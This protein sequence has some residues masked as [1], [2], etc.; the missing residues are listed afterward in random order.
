MH[1]TFILVVLTEQCHVGCQHCGYIGSKRD[2][3]VE[4]PELEN[5]LDQFRQYGIPEVIFTGG[6]AFERYEL[7]CRGVERARTNG[8]RSGVFTSAFWATSQEKARQ[9]LRELSGLAR[10]HISTDVYHQ[11]RIPPAYVRHA[12]DAALELGIAN[13]RLAITYATGQDKNNISSQFSDY[14][15]RITIYADRVIPNP[16]FSPRV[17]AGQDRLVELSP[18]SYSRNC[19]IGTPLVD[20]SGE[21]FA[22]HIG[23]AAAHRDLTKLPF[24][25]GNLRSSSFAT[26]MKQ[27]QERPD[28]Q[29]LRT[30]GPRGVAEMACQTPSLLESLPRREFT[31][32][33]DMCM[34]ILKSEKGADSLRAYAADKR[35]T[36]NTVLAFRMA[37]Q[38]LS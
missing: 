28:Y 16:K 27:A 38:P 18:K 32:A 35:D 29:F 26:I 24:Y 9:T 13:I 11:K 22:C 21:I 17:L 19:W 36:I 8:L 5:W 33:C 12:I 2:G 1:F 3:E 37:E 30:H 7:L 4:A 34:S 14:G 20:P 23:K 10:L 31:T 15:N 25:V 6:E